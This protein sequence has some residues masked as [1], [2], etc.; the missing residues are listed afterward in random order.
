VRLWRFA[1]A[2][3]VIIPA[4]ATGCATVVP[5]PDPAAPVMVYIADYGRHTSLL[6]PRPEGGLIEYAYG[7]W[8]WFAQGDDRL[9]RAPGVL[10]GPNE[11]TL[12]RRELPE[13]HGA[14][15]QSLTGAVRTI[16]VPVEADDA[17]ALAA[18]L[19][20]RFDAGR[21]TMVYNLALDMEFIRDPEPYSLSNNSNVATADW[22]REL[23]CR[24]QGPALL[25]GFRIHAPPASTID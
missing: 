9:I 17:A 15:P 3:S 18:R 8:A 1:A 11:G 21:D 10:L 25:S 22:L 5:P 4:A 20:A 16:A 14:D 2:C 13:A 12:G 6:V 19:Q 24:I 23:G 7:E